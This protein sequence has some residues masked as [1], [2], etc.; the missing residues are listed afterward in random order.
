MGTSTRFEGSFCGFTGNSAPR[1]RGGAV[2]A[3][4]DCDVLLRGSNAANNAA[5]F[6]GGFGSFY[7]AASVEIIDSVFES[8]ELLPQ[9]SEEEEAGGGGALCIDGTSDVRILRSSFVGNTVQNAPSDGG[10]IL[11]VNSHT[12]FAGVHFAENIAELGKSTC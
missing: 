10:A 12:V 4:A 6:K 8:N 2:D 7:D 9:S 11:A 1:G 3:T 5:L